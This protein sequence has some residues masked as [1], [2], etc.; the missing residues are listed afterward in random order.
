MSHDLTEEEV[1]NRIANRGLYCDGDP[2]LDGLKAERD[3]AK[4]LVARF[5]QTTVDDVELR[6]R[7][8]GELFSGDTSDVFIEPP[9]SVAYG[10]RT[11]FSG[12]TYANTGL[13]LVDDYEI[14]IG[15]N[16]MFAPNVTLTATGH[17]VHPDSRRDGTQ[18]SAPI[19][20]E[21]DV[22]IGAHAVVLPGVTIGRGS[23]VAAGAVVTKNV[24]PMSVVGGVPAKLIRKITDDD[25]N[26]E[27]REPSDL[28]S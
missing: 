8:V 6:K 17:P 4:R 18:F 10:Y 22:W 7:L 28:Q 20:I 19:I 2:G 26:W 11:T 15:K 24:P 21:D 9:I 14:R 5:N 27:Y 12:A 13:T 23:V 1:R 16:V 3:R 25:R